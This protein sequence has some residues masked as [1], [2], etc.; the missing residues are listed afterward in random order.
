M[1]RMPNARRRKRGNARTIPTAG[2]RNQPPDDQLGANLL[3]ELR[4][5][6]AAAG[7]PAEIMQ[8]LDGPGTPE[9]VLQ[10]AVSSGLLPSP[11]GSTA[12][13]VSSWEPLLARG[14]DP[15]EAELA[16]WDFLAMMRRNGAS[17]DD[18]PEML[19]EM[20]AQAEDHGDRAALAMLRALAVVAPPPARAAAAE[21]ADRLVGAGLTDPAW[22]KDLG[23]PRFDSSFGY[24]DILGA[25][26]AVAVCFRYGRKRHAVCVLIDHDLG[27]GVKD[28]WATDQV[29]EVRGGYQE[30]ADS[31]LITY[32][33]YGPAEVHAI[34][35]A[36]LDGEPCPEQP[37]QIE[38]VSVHLDLLR[39]R[40]ALLAGMAAISMPPGARDA[41][42]GGTVH[43]LKIG[44]KGAKPPIWRRL[45]VPS[46]LSLDAVHH[47]IQV[48][49]G[50]E[51]YHLWSFETPQGHY[52]PPEAEFGGRAASVRLGQ[53][54]GGSGDRLR[55][56]YDFGDDWVHDIVVEE[57]VAAEPG[58]AYPRCIAGRRAAPPE[59]CGGIWGYQ[60][61]LEVLDDPDHPEHRDRLEWLGV[62]SAAEVDPALFDRDTVNKSLAGMSRTLA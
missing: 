27:G 51:D 62:G 59:D 55:Y 47:V 24:A 45:E 3:A 13:I 16:G 17:G 37:D 50:W 39:Q 11:G 56:T 5:A 6:L 8:I 10:R 15:L 9:E 57:V 53:V 34:L 42:V 48:A 20:V 25:Q 7:A 44:L 29:E 38:D 22:A 46:D 43:R 35:A 52:S 14:T 60:Y 40:V 61:L 54:A 4:Q 32:R 49:F 12:G 31:G 58:M 1:A 23:A 19:Q 2:N 21:A 30:M 26:E 41:S 18:L 28:C 36:A 33:E